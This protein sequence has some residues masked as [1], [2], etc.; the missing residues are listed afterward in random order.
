MQRGAALFDLD[1]TIAD[2]HRLE[3][4]RRRRMWRMVYDLIPTHVYIY[5][6]IKDIFDYL[7]GRN[8]GI[9]VITSSP[10]I[11]CSK[12]LDYL[13]LHV[14]VIVGYHDTVKKKP[15]P[16]PINLA[17]SKLSA[18]NIY[19]F[20]AGDKVDDIIAAKRANV[21]SIACLW[22]SSMSNTE[23]QQI[24]PDLIF[25]NPR[26]FFYWIKNNY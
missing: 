25:D 16:E 10:R 20:Y 6:F 2:T 9:G 11:Y 1:Q 22:D 19:S 8:I 4:Y 5:P 7:N 3:D 13:G 15:H 26:D 14:D 18:H 23:I 17:L 21:L 24:K 12:V